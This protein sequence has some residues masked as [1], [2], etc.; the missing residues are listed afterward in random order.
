[1][2][3]TGNE[4]LEDKKQREN[5]AQCLFA[6]WNLI[7]TISFRMLAGRRLGGRLAINLEL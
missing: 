3:E 2:L 1:M 4:A 6:G 7:V 5:A